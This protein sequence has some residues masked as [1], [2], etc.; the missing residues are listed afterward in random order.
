MVE[1]FIQTIRTQVP[2]STLDQQNKFIHI[3]TTL[4][5]IPG[6]RKWRSFW[7]STVQRQTSLEKKDIIEA[8]IA[9]YEP[10]LYSEE[11]TFQ[12]IKIIKTIIA[13]HVVKNHLCQKVGDEQTSPVID[14]AKLS[15]K[16]ISEICVQLVEEGDHFSLLWLIK[17]TT[18]AP[19]QAPTA[20]NDSLIGHRL[21]QALQPQ[22]HPSQS[23]TEAQSLEQQ[24]KFIQILTDL[25]LNSGTLLV[26]IIPLMFNQLSALG[27][28]SIPI[29][30][31][32]IQLLVQ[33]S[34]FKDLKNFARSLSQTKEPENQHI[35]RH[36]LASL[37]ASS[38]HEII[39]HLSELKELLPN[40]N[41]R[42]NNPTYKIPFLKLFNDTWTT[43]EA[44]P[45]RLSSMLERGFD[46]PQVHGTFLTA[47]WKTNRETGL[48]L[49][50]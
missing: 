36:L 42:T 32:F 2:A 3:L 4:L 28:D 26:S 27:F 39:L 45:C 14:L 16:K 25:C 9:L 30:L 19:Y 15:T 6:S 23:D 34:T 43:I 5:L 10:K 17:L 44:I 35:G 24:I 38:F 47:I 11:T 37:E 8:T 7:K 48:L 20:K 31:S 46:Y 40:L 12:S 50:I 29:S 49:N 22:A 33:H 1:C 18:N 21:I 13:L 41:F